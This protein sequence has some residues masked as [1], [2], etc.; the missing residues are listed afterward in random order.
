MT[1]ESWCE[2]EESDEVDGNDVAVAEEQDDGLV[3]LLFL[4]V[5]SRLACFNRIWW[6]KVLSFDSSTSMSGFRR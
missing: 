6:G 3:G 2:L 5:K 4:V 1:D